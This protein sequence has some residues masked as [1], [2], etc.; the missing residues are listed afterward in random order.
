MC[1]GFCDWPVGVMGQSDMA[2]L[3]F[4][5]QRSTPITEEFFIVVDVLPFQSN[6][7]VNYMNRAR[8]FLGMRY[9]RHVWSQDASSVGRFI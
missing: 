7:K 1:A 8:F 2:S 4:H 6:W 9:K 5:I 3:P